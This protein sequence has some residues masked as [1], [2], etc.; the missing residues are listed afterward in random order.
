MCVGGG[1]VGVLGKRGCPEVGKGPYIYLFCVFK[2]AIVVVF[3][4]STS[5]K[6]FLVEEEFPLPE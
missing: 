1:G 6:Q 2:I 3:L 4:S 5:Q